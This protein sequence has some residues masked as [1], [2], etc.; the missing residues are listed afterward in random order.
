MAAKGLFTLLMATHS[1]A[2]FHMPATSIPFM[3]STWMW[4]GIWWHMMVPEFNWVELSR[5][6]LQRM[7]PCVAIKSLSGSLLIVQHALVLRSYRGFLP[8]TNALMAVTSPHMMNRFSLQRKSV[9]FHHRSTRLTM[10]LRRTKS[11][12]NILWCTLIV[13]PADRESKVCFI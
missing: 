4:F 3:P 10:I 11:G 13:Q 2:S 7:T 8:Q 6:A 12:A 5:S 9:N 1:V